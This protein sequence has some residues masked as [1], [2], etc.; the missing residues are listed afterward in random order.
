MH[1]IHRLLPQAVSASLPALLSLAYY[2]SS[3]TIKPTDDGALS[4]MRS[5]IGSA[6][7]TALAAHSRAKRGYE[8][9][10]TVG[11]DADDRF[12]SAVDVGT[13]RD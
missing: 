13:P 4:P 3:A 1:L 10:I 7:A 5:D 9:I 6:L 12:M 8:Y 2:Q 11:I